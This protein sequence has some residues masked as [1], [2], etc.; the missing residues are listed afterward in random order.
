M[1]KKTKS[2]WNGK[3]DSF[4]KKIGSDGYWLRKTWDLSR[5]YGWHVQIYDRNHEIG[6]GFHKT[7]K[8]TAIKI[9][10]TELDNLYGINR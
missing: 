2:F 8:F 3:Y 9:A 10:R 4:Y 5:G 7:N 6:Y 1:S